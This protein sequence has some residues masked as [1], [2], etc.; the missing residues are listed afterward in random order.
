MIR[1]YIID[2]ESA[3]RVT[4]KHLLSKIEP[5]VQIVGEADSLKQGLAEIRKAK[6]DVLFLDIEMPDHKGLEIIDLID[7]SFDFE[8]VF[9]TAYSEY[10]I[11]AF[12]LSAFDYLLKPVR[13]NEIQETLLRLQTRLTKKLSSPSLAVLSA[14]LKD[15]GNEKYL[16][17]THSEEFLINVNDII[18]LE[19]DGMYT[20]IVLANK[21][22]TASKPM[23]EILEDLPNFF[24][25][26]HRS[27]S[28]N[29]KQ[30][31]HPVRL[32]SA[33]VKTKIDHYVAVSSRNRSPFLEALRNYNY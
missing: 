17:R 8:I 26:T 4:L 9:V 10:A 16:L 33:G 5:E 14:N 1:G 32:S 29:L 11:R 25:R 7:F 28:V 13:Q 18:S 3:P 20:H 21:K 6:V 27:Y 24:F 31:G 12:K 2:D 23:K 30:V 15:A 19:A 22:I